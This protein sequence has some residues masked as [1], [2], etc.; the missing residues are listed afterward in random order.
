MQENRLEQIM[1]KK[2]RIQD[3]VLPQ[4]LFREAADLRQIKQQLVIR[5][6]RCLLQL[7]AQG[8]I[9]TSLYRAVIGWLAIRIPISGSDIRSGGN[10]AETAT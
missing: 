6:I 9:E 4:M 1:W 10:P 7:L 8:S 5:K 2:F 3:A